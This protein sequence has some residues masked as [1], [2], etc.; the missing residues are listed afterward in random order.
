MR[1]AGTRE[2]PAFVWAFGCGQLRCEVLGTCG[3]KWRGSRR[4]SGGIGGGAGMTKGTKVE[5]TCP[6]SPSDHCVK[7]AT[8]SRMEVFTERQ[9]P[10]VFS[11]SERTKNDVADTRLT[12]LQADRTGKAWVQRIG[13]DCEWSE[14][15]LMRFTIPSIECFRIYARVGSDDQSAVATIS[16]SLTPPNASARG[17]GVW[18]SLTYLQ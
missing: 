13:D 5:G 3:C 8:G 9:V 2:S 14:L 6:E 17:A 7:L 4:A 16:L 18:A 10:L 15:K 1:V 11:P 12:P